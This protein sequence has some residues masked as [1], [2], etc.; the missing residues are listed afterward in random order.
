MGDSDYIP[1][2]ESTRRVRAGMSEAGSEFNYHRAITRQNAVAV[3]AVPD[4]IASVVDLTLDSPKDYNVVAH[5]CPFDWEAHFGRSVTPQ[6]MQM[7]NTAWF[8]GFHKTNM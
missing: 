5:K 6:V 3:P 4:T 2:A 8:F 7:L 1:S